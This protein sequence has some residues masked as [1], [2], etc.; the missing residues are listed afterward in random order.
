[1]NI[2]DYITAMARRTAPL[3]APVVPSSTPVVSFGD[4]RVAKVATL[5]INPSVNEFF[6]DGI[7]LRGPARRLAT[8]ES[9]GAT[10][11]DLLTDEQVETVVAECWSY[12][13]RQ[14]F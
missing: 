7:L 12:F 2:P 11:C 6:E 10:S 3:S 5:G 9:L 8:V 4:P 14:P 13:R 1:M